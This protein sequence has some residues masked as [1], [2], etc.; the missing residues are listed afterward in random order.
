MVLRGICCCPWCTNAASLPCR[1]RNAYLDVGPY[2]EILMLS[3]ASVCGC[4]CCCCCQDR[5]WKD[6]TVSVFDL[7]N[8]EEDG[9]LRGEE[10]P[11]A[12]DK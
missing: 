6:T 4:C 9:Q 10:M 11:W 12:N 5:A 3:P 2:A 8:M 7:E 1:K